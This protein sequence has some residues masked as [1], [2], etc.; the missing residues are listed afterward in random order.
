[1][2]KLISFLALTALLAGCSTYNQHTEV[3]EEEMELPSSTFYAE[4]FDVTGGDA[5]GAVYMTFIDFLEDTGEGA[6][7]LTAGFSDLKTPTDN[8]FY[9]GW[10]VDTDNGDVISTGVAYLEGD[11]YWINDFEDSV[12]LTGYDKYVLTYEPDDGDPA[13][14]DHVLDGYFEYESSF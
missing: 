3:L 12:D 1:M 9:E 2:K 13:P 5:S 10:L 11:D 7:I 8:Y 4:L 14:A 6:L